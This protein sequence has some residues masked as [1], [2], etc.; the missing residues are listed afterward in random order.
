MAQARNLPDLIF[1][2]RETPPYGHNFLHV[3]LGLSHRPR[4]WGS[5]GNAGCCGHVA[6]RSLSRTPG[7]EKR[8]SGGRGGDVYDLANHV[9]TSPTG[10]T[11]TTR[12]IPFQ[13][14][15]RAVS[16]T[17]I[18]PCPSAKFLAACICLLINSCTVDPFE[19]YLCLSTVALALGEI[20]C[21]AEMLTL[22]REAGMPND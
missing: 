19:A 17:R 2:A 1:Q 22:P 8:D 3:L 18:Y 11:T 10:T 5:G 20:T 12:Y 7:E 15:S 4:S 13:V 6:G 14:T 21:T 16:A 9:G